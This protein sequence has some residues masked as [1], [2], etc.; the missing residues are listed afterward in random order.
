MLDFVAPFI[1]ATEIQIMQK[2]IGNSLIINGG[3]IEMGLERMDIVWREREERNLLWQMKSCD[4]TVNWLSETSSFTVFYLVLVCSQVRLLF[5]F[6][7][8]CIHFQSKDKFHKFWLMKK[9]LYGNLVPERKA[10]QCL[11]K[12]AEICQIV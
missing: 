10:L 8:H 5:S 2:A 7:A 11:Q 3:G 1:N 9:A 6:F 4:L 12:R